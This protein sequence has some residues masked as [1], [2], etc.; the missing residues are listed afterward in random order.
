MLPRRPKEENNIKFKA[1]KRHLSE[2]SEATRP[3]KSRKGDQ[4]VEEFQYT[5]RDYKTTEELAQAIESFTHEVEEPK[6]NEV[7]PPSGY[8]ANSQ[9]VRRIGSGGLRTS[10]RLDVPSASP[11]LLTEGEVTICDDSGQDLERQF[12]K[13]NAKRIKARIYLPNKS[14]VEQVRNDLEA[15]EAKLESAA[16]PSRFFIPCTL[17]K[18]ILSQETVGLIIKELYPDPAT[19]MSKE[20]LAP[21]SPGP[22][23]PSFRRTIAVLILIRRERDLHWFVRKEMHDSELPFDY[24]TL[25]EMT[26]TW[27][28]DWGPQ[29]YRD[30]CERKHEVSPVFFAMSGFLQKAR[31]KIVHYHFNQGEILPFTRKHWAEQGG[32]GE[33]MKYDLHQ[34]QQHLRRYTVRPLEICRYLT[35]Q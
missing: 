15:D 11:S 9:N 24:R 6:S 19:G 33:V 20:T 25:K 10:G 12:L 22:G 4:E 30:F 21:E 1:G 2:D 8:R 27:A 29:D 13:E 7:T 16:S 28:L 14:I 26:L 32:F 35:Y 34:D 3:P 5:K 31:K 23:T 17:L 18:E